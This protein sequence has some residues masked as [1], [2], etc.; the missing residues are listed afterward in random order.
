MFYSF[1]PSCVPKFTTWTYCRTGRKTP[2]SAAMLSRPRA[3]MN[4]EPVGTSGCPR[5][6]LSTVGE[7]HWGS[8]CPDGWCRCIP[9]FLAEAHASKA[10]KR[11]PADEATSA[12]RPKERVELGLQTVRLNCPGRGKSPGSTSPRFFTSICQCEGQRGG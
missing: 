1:P 10:L 7:V 9:V 2:I 6:D 5:L 8:P 3:G 12:D 4:G 11:E